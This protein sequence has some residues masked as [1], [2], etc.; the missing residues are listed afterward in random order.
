MF[1]WLL[2]LKSYIPHLL[3][4]GDWLAGAGLCYCYL[5]FKIQRACEKA[6]IEACCFDRLGV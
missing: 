3:T 6:C 5:P 2:L 1:W 4:Y